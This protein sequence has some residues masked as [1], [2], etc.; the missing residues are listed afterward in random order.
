MKLSCHQLLE[1][2]S[3][4]GS[5]CLRIKYSKQLCSQ[6]RLLLYR[7]GKSPLNSS[8]ARCESFIQSHEDVRFDLRPHL[9]ASRAGIAYITDSSTED[10]NGIV[11]VDLGTHQPWRHLDGMPVVHSELP[12]SQSSGASRSTASP[13]PV[14]YSA[15]L[16]LL[17]GTALSSDGEIPTGQP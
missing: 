12:S 10:R 11:V 14:A 13:D 2:Q 6:P 7:F 3:L 17:D 4:S 16:M 9:T 5:T 1:G 8:A 15:V